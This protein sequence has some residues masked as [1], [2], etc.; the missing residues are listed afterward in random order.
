MNA[1]DKDTIIARLT[2][3]NEELNAQIAKLRLQVREQAMHTH[4]AKQYVEETH[5]KMA[6]IHVGAHKRVAAVEEQRSGLV[7]G[8][9]FGVSKEPGWDIS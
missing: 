4:M 2:A 8:Q 6:Q 3:E 7:E 9:R 5:A 1:Q